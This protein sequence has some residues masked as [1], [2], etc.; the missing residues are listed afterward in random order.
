MGASTEAANNH[1]QEVSVV[2]L[3]GSFCGVHGWRGRILSDLIRGGLRTPRTSFMSVECLMNVRKGHGLET[4]RSRGLV[5]DVRG[6]D[7]VV[8]AADVD[9]GS[10]AAVPEHDGV[11]L[12]E[13]QVQARA[14]ESP[15][16]ERHNRHLFPAVHARVEHRRSVGWIHCVV[17]QTRVR[18]GTV[19]S[20]GDCDG[21]GSRGANDR[22]PER[23]EFVW[24]H[25]NDRF[26]LKSVVNPDKG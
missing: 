9:A 26:P 5:R 20:L 12:A 2:P 25:S 17:R 8:G 6:L 1:M 22:E 16:E 11:P 4:G 10:R 24:L 21:A 23:G 13:P 3:R 19:R 7:A 15:G 18:H 14:F